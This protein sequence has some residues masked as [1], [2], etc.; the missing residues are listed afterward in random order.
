VYKHKL[1]VQMQFL[2]LSYV[3]DLDVRL[4]WTYFFYSKTKHGSNVTLKREV[5]LLFFFKY[6]SHKTHEA[7]VIGNKEVIILCHVSLTKFF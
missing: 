1:E 6:L 2:S 7:R 5:V 3:I 4:L